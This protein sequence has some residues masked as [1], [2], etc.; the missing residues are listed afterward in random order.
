MRGLIVLFL[1]FLCACQPNIS[2]TEVPSGTGGHLN[3]NPQT[4]NEEWNMLYYMGTEFEE[5]VFIESFECSE[6]KRHRPR[7]IL[8]ASKTKSIVLEYI[9]PQKALAWKVQEN[10]CGQLADESIDIEVK[11][12]TYSS[13][14][15]Q[16]GL[17]QYQAYCQLFV[18]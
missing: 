8:R 12:C 13:Y 11:S 6:D 5:S 14:V 16:S 4:D 18:R 2:V 17:R 15:D 3:I 7:V 9:G 10:Y 1:A